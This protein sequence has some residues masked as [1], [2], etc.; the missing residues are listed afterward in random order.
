MP[1]LPCAT[2]DHVGGRTLPSV[3]SL[4]PT[5]EPPRAP[6][7]PGQQGERWTVAVADFPSGR[8]RGVLWDATIE[9]APVRARHLGGNELT[10][11][12]PL[13]Y[14]VMRTLGTP[15][16]GSFDLAGRQ[17][18]SL[19]NIGQIELL[20]GSNVD[21]LTRRR[22]V[23]RGQAQVANGRVT[24]TAQGW[25]GGITADRSIGAPTR[26]NLIK[27]NSSF[28]S[29]LTGWTAHGGAVATIRTG[30][31]DG[32]KYVGIRGPEG[33]YLER[34]I[35]FVEPPRPWGRQR[36]AGTALVKLPAGVDI[37]DFG[38][39]SVAVYAGGKQWWPS[40]TLGDPDAGV[41]TSDM[42]RGSWITDAVVAFGYLPT[43][44]FNA[45][46]CLRLWAV[47]EVQEVAFDDTS[48]IRRENTSTVYPWDLVRH[49][50][51]L[52]DHAQRHESKNDWGIG[53]EEGDPTGI[54]EVGTWWHEDGTTLPE[55]LEK[56]G[57]RGLDL[58][59]L[60]GP[61]RK[62]MS[63]KRQGRVRHDIR[64]NAW[65]IIGPRWSVDPGAQ[66]TAA[67]AVSSAGSVWG[68][69][70]EG[71]VDTSQSGGQVIDVTLS[72]PA[73][74]T[75]T[76]TREWLAH[77]LASLSTVPISA[78]VRVPY[79]LGIRLDVGDTVWIDFRSESASEPGWYRI[80]E[81]DPDFKGCRYVDLTVGLDTE[82]GRT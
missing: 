45:E 5:G 68:G 11:S 59:D 29:G 72:A 65:D 66:R 4:P 80:T 23:V 44:P 19:R 61:G 34:R 2:Y 82:M 26:K 37:D 41:V 42:V 56:L 60:P 78:P 46:V 48:I 8:F 70:D 51:K 79:R 53:V 39:V 27:T 33:A 15:V 30:G 7:Q 28:E 63:T 69:A 9:K 76:Q 35:P 54:V 40:A 57:G 14:R 62:V 21:G 22:F 67:R 3:P 71:A 10:I 49:A 77:E 20:L 31:P 52:F 64:I 81:S 73:G 50:S 17:R 18:Y 12:A 24:V 74:L 43:P 1:S 55:G 47:D 75:P 16:P 13:N 32:G 6:A 25:I 38:L 36:I 58:Y